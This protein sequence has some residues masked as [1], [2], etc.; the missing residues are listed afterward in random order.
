MLASTGGR[1][2]SRDQYTCLLAAGGFR[3]ERFVPTQSA[4]FVVEA[5][6]V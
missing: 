2:R 1:E 4:F 6:A 3:L 5:T